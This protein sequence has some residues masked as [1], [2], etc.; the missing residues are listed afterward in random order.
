MPRLVKVLLQLAELHGSIIY[1]LNAMSGVQQICCWL[2]ANSIAHGDVIVRIQQHIITQAKL[3]TPVA[4]GIRAFTEIY[5]QYMQVSA[6]GVKELLQLAHFP[7]T[8]LAP[9]CPEIYY[10]DFTMEVV[11]CQ[12]LGCWCQQFEGRRLRTDFR[13]DIKFAVGHETCVFCTVGQ[14]RVNQNCEG[15]AQGKQRGDQLTYS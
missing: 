13:C 5:R 10:G 2:T 12:R 6:M 3:L 7:A 14:T 4:Y 9:G 8:G 11:Q 15:R 1:L